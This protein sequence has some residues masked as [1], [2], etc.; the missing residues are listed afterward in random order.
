MEM[1]LQDISK[2]FNIP[3]YDTVLLKAFI[4]FFVMGD[5][6]L[7]VYYSNL[8]SGMSFFSVMAS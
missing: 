1:W 4:S 5:K 8:N 7:S 6:K 2:K 3:D